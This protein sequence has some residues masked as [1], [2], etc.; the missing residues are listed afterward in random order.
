M[1]GNLPV[2]LDR[3]ACLGSSLT[4]RFR[5]KLDR[6]WRPASAAAIGA[7]KFVCRQLPLE[8]A[9]EVVES[10]DQMRTAQSPAARNSSLA[11]IEKAAGDLAFSRYWGKIE[12]HRNRLAMHRSCS[13]PMLRDRIRPQKCR[14]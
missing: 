2:A 11:S 8:L 3:R 13:T 14:R 6:D 1:N 7:R 5:M 10:Q 4:R 9:R 12:P